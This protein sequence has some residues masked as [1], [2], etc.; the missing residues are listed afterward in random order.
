[1]QLRIIP[2]KNVTNVRLDRNATLAEIEER[3]RSSD[4]MAAHPRIAAFYY[5]GKHVGRPNSNWR[6]KGHD[7]HEKYSASLRGQI[8]NANVLWR[9]RMEICMEPI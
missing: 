9:R 1:M 6:K 4:P 5:G 3:E 2:A 7:L 8:N